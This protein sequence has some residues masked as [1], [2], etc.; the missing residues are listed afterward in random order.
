MPGDPLA[1]VSRALNGSPES[2]ASIMQ[3]YG[4]DKPIGDQYFSYVKSMLTFDFGMSFN[5][6]MPVKDVL[7]PKIKASLILAVWSMPFGIIIGIAMG[8]VAAAFRGKK[9]D[10]AI[11]TTSM[12]IYAIPSFW[13]GM[14]LLSFFAVKLR[15]I[16]VNGMITPGMNY[17][18]YFSYLGDL[19]RHIIVPMLSYSLAIFGSY[20]LIMRSSMIDVFS[21]DFV[22]T[23]RA[24]GL[25]RRKIITDHVVPNALL[26]ITT[27]V[28]TSIAL[29]FTGTFS[30]EIL[31]SW[32]GVG[33]LMVEAV[34]R[35]DYPVM[36]A[37]NYLIAVAVVIAN[38]VVDILYSYLDPRVRVE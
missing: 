7:F 23:A 38:F 18:T 29:M 21:E 12:L 35:Q 17:K 10:T 11:T 19:I 20:F 4:L 14:I 16:P 30:I 3:L 33:R 9:A 28:V 31:F 24:K 27:I 32:P 13:L 1:M 15:L 37:I 22:L 8:I 6:R 25:P 34:T 36:Q 26:P 5:Y 2:R